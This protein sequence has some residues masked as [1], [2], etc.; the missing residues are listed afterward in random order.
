MGTEA[1][2]LQAEKEKLEAEKLAEAEALRLALEE[3][4]ACSPKLP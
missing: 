2:M 1:Q 3:K 4:D